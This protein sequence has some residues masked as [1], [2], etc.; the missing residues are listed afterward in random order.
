MG[1]LNFI[2]RIS[3]IILGNGKKRKKYAIESFFFVVTAFIF[4]FFLIKLWQGRFSESVDG[5]AVGKWVLSWLGIICCFTGAILSFAWGILSEIFI[6]ICSF[7]SI[8]NPDKREGNVAAFIISLITVG[9]I[10]GGVLF[11]IL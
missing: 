10:V 11:F 9:G 7:F 8:F 3:D 6:F 4:A 1:K 2:T 5:E